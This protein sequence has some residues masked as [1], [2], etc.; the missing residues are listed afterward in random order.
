MSESRPL[1]FCHL[2][3]EWD[4]DK[5]VLVEALVHAAD[6]RLARACTKDNGA[7]LPAKFARR[8]SYKQLTRLEFVSEVSQGPLELAPTLGCR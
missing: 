8:P 3:R 5:E 6:A 1:P 4:R 7:S 2:C